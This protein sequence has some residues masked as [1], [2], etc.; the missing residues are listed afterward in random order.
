M[1]RYGTIMRQYPRL[2]VLRGFNPNE[3]HTFTQ[4]YPVQ[5]NVVI[6]S[7]QVVSAVWNAGTSIYEWQLGWTAGLIPF[8]ALNDS[9]DADVVE[10]G[11]LVAL[12]SAGQF[13]LQTAFWKAGD[14]FNVDTPVGPDGVTGNI[15][16]ATL[17]DGNPIMGY[18]TRNHGPLS[19]VGINSNAVNLSVVSYQTNFSLNRS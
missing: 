16:A 17:G 6:L 13:E 3:P 8:T 5:A 19:L 11:N 1:P 14:T 18:I 9:G 2:E 7:G 15:K 4:A 12:S 10:A